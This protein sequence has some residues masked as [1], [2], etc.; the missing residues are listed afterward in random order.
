MVPIDAMVMELSGLLY[1]DGIITLVVRHSRLMLNKNLHNWQRLPFGR[2]WLENCDIWRNGKLLQGVSE[3]YDNF[4]CFF[5]C[6]RWWGKIPI[7]WHI[8]VVV[9][10]QWRV[11]R[12]L[13]EACGGCDASR[14]CWFS[15]LRIHVVWSGVTLSSRKSPWSGLKRHAKETNTPRDGWTRQFATEMTYCFANCSTFFQKSF[16]F[17]K[18]KLNSVLLCFV[19]RRLHLKIGNRSKWRRQNPVSFYFLTPVCVTSPDKRYS[20]NRWEKFG[21]KM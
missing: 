17:F 9:A 2:T 7:V 16:H 20:R 1:C 21:V 11:A 5:F 13:S 18:F 15:P 19:G 4:C 8:N 3:I 6:G 10:H 12:E 14:G